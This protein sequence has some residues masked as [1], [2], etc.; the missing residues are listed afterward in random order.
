MTDHD[1]AIIE[2]AKKTADW[3]RGALLADDHPARDLVTAVDAKREAMKP[4]L[5]TAEEAIN[6]ARWT[7][8][9]RVRQAVEPV[10]TACHERAYRVIEALPH[11]PMLDVGMG[12]AR[13]DGV[14]LH[15]VRAALGIKP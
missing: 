4:K 14:S 11:H 8:C 7:D 3:Y 10:L 12:D 2:A 1:K 6:V 5:L 9:E 15:E 13:H